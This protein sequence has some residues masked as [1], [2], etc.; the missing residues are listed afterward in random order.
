MVCLLKV[1]RFVLC[2]KG[3]ER[4]SA[5]I[6]A[7]AFVELLTPSVVLYLAIGVLLGT[8][9]GA[10]PGL[11]ATMGVALITPITFWLDKVDGFAMLMGLWNAAIFAGGITAILINTPGTPASITQAWDGYPL[12]KEGKGGLV[13]GINVVFSFIGGMIS[14]ILLILLADPIAKI[15]IKFGPA[16]Y[17]MVALFGMTMMI[18]VSN[19]KVLKGIMLGFLGLLLSTVGLCPIS[20]L[21]RFT[22]GSI[23]LQSGINFIPVMIGLLGLGEVFFQVYEYNEEKAKAEMEAR[24][25]SQSLGRVLPSLSEMKKWTPRCVL[26]GIAATIIGAIPAAGGDI[27]AIICWGNSKRFS[28]EG[29]KYGHGSAEGLAVSSSANNGVIGGAMCTMLTLGIPGD[30]VTAV[31]LGSLMMYG[32][33]PGHAMFNEQIG[34]TAQIMVLM[35]FANLAFLVIGLGTAKISAKLLNMSQPTVWAAVGVLCIVGSY[36]INNSFLDV[37]VMFIMGILGFFLKVYDFPSGPLVLGLLLGSTVEKN[38]RTALVI[39][40][41]D[42][43]CFVTRPISLI[44]LILIIASFLIPIIQTTIKKNK[45]RKA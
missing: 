31:L 25:V 18:A 11:S 32:M 10:L 14:I 6:L 17:A 22:F 40:R 24:K 43:S 8:M 30:A 12:Y 23:Q 4:M 27:S 44:L 41:G 2:R 5:H 33:T 28:K 7:S 37:V 13:L 3:G 34:F 45:A 36:C 15:T 9:I 1:L 39:S 38:V 29:E 20:G 42:V 21:Q 19:G 16:E 26:A 35:I